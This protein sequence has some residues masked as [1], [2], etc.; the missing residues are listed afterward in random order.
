MAKKGWKSSRKILGLAV[1][2]AASLLWAGRAHGNVYYFDVNG[3]TAGSGVTNGGS[4]N[5]TDANW[6][7]DS[8][9]SSATTNPGWGGAG[10]DAVFVA[11]TDGGAAAFTVT[12]PGG[13]AQTWVDNLTVNSGNPTIAVNGG[14]FVLGTGS[15]WTVATG[16]TLAVTGAGSGSWGALNMNGNSLIVAGGGNTIV[17]GMG[18]S[19][20]GVTKN[21]TGTLSMTGDSNYSGGT[22]VS[23]GTVVAGARGLG[24]GAVNVGTSG[25]LAVSQT[26]SVGLAGQ[27]FNIGANQ[28]NFASLALLQPS[29]ATTAASQ[30][31]N[32]T[33]LNFQTNGS[34]F[35][36]PYNAGQPVFAAY[37]SG[38]IDIGTGGTY[39]FNTSSDDGS[40]LFIDGVAVVTNNFNQGVTTR[41]GPIVLTAGYHNIVL[42]YNNTGGGYGFIAQISGVNNTNMVD[43]NT[44]N[45]QLTPDLVIGS[46]AGAGNVVLST[47]NLITGTDNSSTTFSGVVSSSGGGAAIAGLNKIGT[48]TLTLTNANTYQGETTIASGA[49]QLGDG[50]TTNGSVAG[51][52]VNYSALIV[53]NPN[54]QTYAGSIRGGGTV[55]KAG[56]GK[57]TLT[58]NNRYTGATLLTSGTIAI[59]TSNAAGLY[60]GLVNGSNANDTS[61][62]IPLTSIQSVARWG[63]STSTDHNADA[64]WN[65]Y[66]NWGDNTT[67]G[68]TGYIDNTS[69]GSVTYNFGKNFDDNA[70][71]VIDGVTVISNTQWNQNV[72]GSIAL[73]PG[74]HSV[75]LRFGQGGGGAGPNTGAYNNYGISYNTVGNTGTGGT[76]LQMGAIDANTQFY[77][78]IAG[79]PGSAVVMSS[80][81]TLDLSANGMGLVGLG[82]LADAAGSPTGHQVLVGAN[83]L[84]TGLDNTSTTFSGGISGAGGNLIKSGTGVFTLA[85]A[86]TFSGTTLVSAGTLKLSHALALQNSTLASAGVVFDSSVGGHAFTLGGLNGSFN[87]ALQDNAGVPNAVALSVGN[88]NTNTT[89]GGVLSAAGSLIKVGTGTLIF[90]SQQTYTGGTTVNGGTLQLNVGGQTGTLANNTNVAVNGG[91]TLLL[92][93]TDALGYNTNPGAVNLTVNSGGIVSDA[94]GSRTT[95]WNTVTMIGGTL[96][97][98]GSGNGD[99]NFNS[100]YSLQ[101]QLNATSDASGNPS[102]I[103]SAATLGLQN[104]NTVLNVTQ[105]A[106]APASDL[107]I[108]ANVGSWNNGA[109]LTKQGNGILKLTGNNVYNGG[110]TITGG[111]VITGGRGFGTGSVNIAAGTVSV[112]QTGGIGLVGQYF[113]IAAAQSD[114]NT[115]QALQASVATPGASEILNTPTLNFLANG[116]GFPAPYNGGQPV[117]VAYYSGMINI[118]ATGT[119]TFNTSSD[120]GSMVYIDGTPVVVNN[121]NQ[122]VT[123]RSGAIPLNS[124]YHNIVVSYNN[125]G[126]NYGLIAQISGANN[127]NMID[128]NTSN[129]QLTPDLVIGSL[130]GAGNV[131]LSTGNLITGTDNTS[132]VFSGSISSSGGG[133]AIAGVNKIGTGVLT[134]TGNNTYNGATTISAGGIQVGSANA[135]A[136][137]TVRVNVNNGLTFSTGVGATAIGALAGSGNVTLSD[138]AVGAVNLAAGSNNA[139]T[140]YTGGMSGNGSFTKSGSGTLV[141]TGN[142][143][144]TGNT[145]ITGGTL[146]IATAG[147]YEGMVSN[148]NG[149]DTGDGIPLTSIQ[150][151]ARWG[152][153]NNTG[154]TNVYPAWGNNTTWG[155]TGFINNTTGGNV[156][157]TFGKNF[158]DGGYLAI[159][160]NVLLNDNTYTDSVTNSITLSPGLHTIDLRFGQ[161]NGGV[162]PQGNYGN[163]GIAYSTNGGN[164]WQQIGNTGD[165]GNSAF[166]VANAAGQQLSTV[167]SVV[168]SSNTTFDVTNGV[169]TIGSLADAGGSPTGSKVLIGGGQLSTGNDNS[170]TTF[171]GAIDGGTLVKVG[172]GTFTI[173]GITDNVGLAVVVNNGTVV[174]A[175]NPSSGSPDVHAVGGGGLT[176]N[177]G[178]A[179]LGGTGG[180]QIHNGSN[181]VI[182]GGGTLDTNGLSETVNALSLAGSGN[183]G[184]GALVNTAAGASVITP[185]GNTTLTADTTIGVTQAG[186]MLTLNNGVSGAHSLTKVGAGVLSLTG[187]AGITYVGNTTVSGGVLQMSDAINFSNGNNPANVINIAA[188]A[189]LT[190]S[191]STNTGFGTDGA[192]Q[193][194]GTTNGTSITGTGTFQKTGP[195]ILALGG[196]GGNGET[197]NMNMTGGTIDVEGGMLR[198]GGWAGGVWTNNKASLNIAGGATFDMWDGNNVNVDALT[199][200]GTVDKNQT[201]SHTEVL[202]V[203]VNNGSGVFSGTIQNS[204]TNG[205]GVALVKTGSGSQTVSGNN[206]YIGGTTVTGGILIAGSRALSGGA[207]NVGASGTLS[208]FQTGSV[209]LAGQYFNIGAAQSNFATLPVLQ[210]TIATTTA[211]EILNTTNLNFQTNGS[212]FPAPYNA[213]QPVFVGYYSGMINIGASGT[214]TFNTSSDDGSMLFVDGSAVVINN[215]NQGVTTRSGSVAL[216]SGYHNIVLAY[217]NTGGNYG[218]V[219]Q[220]SGVNNNNMVD[221]N[222]SNAQLTP[223][224]VIGSLAGAGSVVLSTGNLITGTDN[225]STV[226][227][228]SI[229]S[230][231]GGAAIAGLNKIGT[232]T[233]T[234]TGNSTYYGDTSISGGAVQVGSANAIQNS[235][236]NVNINNGLKFSAGLGSTAIGGLAGSG[237]LA[238]TDQANAGV[239]LTAGGNNAN[240]TYAGSMSGTGGSFAKAGSGTLALAGANNYTGAT[241]VTGGTLKLAAAGLYEGLVSNSDG[242]NT[243]T[244]FPNWNHVSIQQTARWGT[245][246]NA[247][248]DN[249]FPNWGDNST[250][251][252][253]GYI[254]NTTG[255]NVT[256][257][258]GKNFDDSAYLKIDNT[259]VINDGAYNNHTIA[260]ISL[261]PGLH[262]I[263]LLFGQG[264]GGVGTTDGSYSGYGVAYN[265][266]GNTASSGTWL[267]IGPGSADTAFFAYSGQLPATSSVVMSSNTTLDLGGAPATIGSLADA[268]GNPIGAQVLIGGGQLTTGNDNTN[269]MFSG[270]ISGNSLI[271]V[272]SGTFTLSGAST[273]TGGTTLNAGKLIVANT[274]GSATGAGPVTVASSAT[275]SGSTAPAQG[276]IQGGVTV[277]GG[278]TLAASSGAVL[279]IAGGLAFD[280]ASIATFALSGTPNGTSNG[281]V[282]ITGGSFTGGGIGGTTINITGTPQIGT[283]DLFDFAGGLPALNN[284]VIGAN[285]NGFVGTLVIGPN[286]IDLTETRPVTWTGQTGGNG[287]TDTSW[288]TTGSTNWA[289]NTPSAITYADTDAV[290]FQD[291]NVIAGGNVAVAS[292]SVVIQAAGVAPSSVAFTN[293]NIDYSVSNASGAIG[294]T[295]ATAVTKAG[296]GTVIFNS[297]NTYSGGTTVTGGILQVN[298]DN[299]LGSTAT[300]TVSGGELLLSNVAYGNTQS[301]SIAG[302][303]V[304]NAGALA[305]TGT[306]SF[307]GAVALAADASIGAA[308]GSTLT[309][310][311]GVSATSATVSFTG[312]GTININTVGISG[313][314]NAVVAGGAGTNL[315]FNTPNSFSSGIQVINNATLTLGASNVLPSSPAPDVTVGT[316]TG[317]DVA[318]TFNLNTHSD[319]MGNLILNSGTVSGGGNLT[320]AGVTVNYGGNL[321]AAGTTV[322]GTVNQSDFSSLTLNGT[323]S[324]SDTLGDNAGLNGT[325]KVN[326]VFVNN[327]DTLSSAGT[328]TVTNTGGFHI[329][330]TG[331]VI[332]SGTISLGATGVG[333]ADQQVGSTLAV[334]GTLRGGDV[335]DVSAALSGSG[336]I[337]GSVS[338]ADSDL[339]SS[340]ATLTIKGTLDVNGV[341]TQLSS[342]TVAVNGITTINAGA[343]LTVNGALSDAS[344]VSIDGKL[345]VGDAS[346]SSATLSSTGVTVNSGGT[347]GGHG[348]ITGPVSV[349]SGGTVEPGG[350][351][352]TLTIAGTYTQGDNTSLT[353]LLNTPVPGHYSMI[354]VT[355]G[356]L[357]IGNNVEVDVSGTV[358]PGTYH[359][360]VYDDGLNGLTTGWF[361]TGIPGADSYVFSTATDGEVDLIITGP[362]P[363]PTSLGLLGLGALSLLR[364]KARKSRA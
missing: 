157:Y 166:V 5:W 175:K 258:F 274:T 238:L 272:G 38:M 176:V 318:S 23:A 247:G 292:R 284:F 271:K 37:Y 313:T 123:T 59:N 77:A 112:S 6:T 356:L 50:A 212:G 54:P 223:D 39:T 27:Y 205:G 234:L 188:G 7:T 179:Q 45:A 144:Y 82:S 226:F 232:G 65:A 108:N 349:G 46:L 207:V 155:Y 286:Q 70:Y 190:L 25:T 32:T 290:T 53:A 174:L 202:T 192:N 256:Y 41:S 296:S 151:T 354:D 293:S 42:A 51:N 78:V 24:S 40:M 337:T 191:V 259:I 172:S 76:W 287:G 165:A 171:S 208:V 161:G 100:N 84:D 315:V 269:T 28:S 250:W 363:E 310:T 83:T 279:T 332:T 261:S 154:G 275:L 130:A 12:L 101:G 140:T 211:S 86:T 162:G 199:G 10:N 90:T 75:D 57:L 360:F 257:T 329:V 204:N 61:S 303:G 246:T 102:V 239:A 348:T 359:L 73:G 277:Q 31:L 178:T 160:N 283:Y 113:N 20:G 214:Y 93:T 268:G 300:T 343:D 295:G 164:S 201:S 132:T 195:G 209:G 240:T 335:L 36:A 353:Y 298:V 254:D 347:L 309:L 218:F 116:S 220:I 184:A 14:N 177:G 135:I 58:G 265:T 19:G 119:Y 320:T 253:T 321:I 1:A 297:V 79:A 137:S 316:G 26:G 330:G 248:G 98:T 106:L 245:S 291:T 340:T 107:T 120:D 91:G 361:A 307:A 17:A 252:Y 13:G 134:L 235:T 125:T 336:T 280:A 242:F 3:A 143:T 222:T 323:F 263:N 227:S 168:M 312:G 233:L 115:L 225:T 333:S 35:P 266:I 219:A 29:L 136:N 169:L 56:A 158:D 127:V 243:G 55:T 273:Y 362:V 103:T 194:L 237:N 80:N 8:T 339:L 159:D 189:T 306:S 44:A 358:A 264:G 16:S 89:F 96:T 198:N 182:N 322:G 30:I 129:A 52:I 118:G 278:G 183:G 341:G 231:G 18:N 344:A 63:A 282:N 302:S 255:G 97:A 346:H 142:N 216:N 121:F 48:G 99:G 74:L 324:G 15:T 288:N 163:F 66:P 221:L 126:G 85:G 114:S 69:N 311:G 128:L 138:Q 153:T 141:L 197:V 105:G 230:S 181:V 185:N 338:L 60:E 43:L 326:S 241:Y 308:S 342:G 210:P 180:D 9:G 193:G 317:G 110:T 285:P 251:G 133:A 260:S 33:N 62:A 357:T 148:S 187:A 294:I 4:Y 229:S 304:A 139:N 328:L 2:G 94:G 21:G 122:G 156:T 345:V 22:T 236:V 88:N 167:T 95:L 109:G 81:T 150:Q 170:N 67:W 49:L 334:N 281:M 350:S 72:T 149:F 352:G 68:Y 228:G 11:G 351:I 262:T 364:R 301:L 213:G 319:S 92:N 64:N 145:N 267:Q 289:S 147:L 217:N 224:L 331:N 299:A 111:T 314:P 305:A 206:T 186:A 244:A 355:G 87:M 276:F 104:G 34:G 124:G 117:F 270:S 200:S 325:G 327:N 71:L 196:Q 131:V 152:A 146:K 203:G 173:A 249:V 47:G 215:A